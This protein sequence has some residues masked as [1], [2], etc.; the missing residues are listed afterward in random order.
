MTPG[1]SPPIRG[2]RARRVLLRHWH[3][4]A[5]LQNTSGSEASGLAHGYGGRIPDTHSRPQSPGAVDTVERYAVSADEGRNAAGRQAD[6]IPFRPFLVRNEPN[7]NTTVPAR[8]ASAPG[9]GGGKPQPAPS[10]EY[11]TRTSW[12]ARRLAR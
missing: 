12:L 4:A 3:R 8:S 2:V 9:L 10:P 5:I 11:A 6:R 1:P 7:V